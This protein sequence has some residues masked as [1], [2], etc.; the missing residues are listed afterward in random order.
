MRYIGLD[1]HQRLT[2]VVWLD[3]ETGE[4]SEAYEVP[5][6]EL[7]DHLG[8]LAGA[9]KKAVLEAGTQSHFL[10]R[11]LMTLGLEVQV[12]HP[13]RVRRLFEALYGLK[14]T[15]KIDARGLALALAD[16]YLERAGV[17][18]ADPPTHELRALTR[19]R[20]QLVECN[21][22]LRNSIRQLVEQ[23]GEVCPYRDLTGRGATEWL[24]EF[25]EG[26]PEPIRLAL[27]A[28]RATLAVM[29]AQIKELSREI[30]QLVKARAEVELLETIPGIGTET[31]AAIVAEI[32]DISRFETATALRGYS[33]LVP[34]VDQSAGK[35]R[36]GP[37]TKRGNRRLRRI[38]ILA[39]QHF[40]Q[41]KATR[42]LS[43]RKWHARQVFRHGPNPAKV[44]V[45]RR[46][47]N[48]IFALLR[49]QAAFDASRYA[50]PDAA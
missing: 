14:K 2:T 48:I 28:Q 15:D 30:A 21:V 39:A 13:F 43:L 11:R 8:S 1:V 38:M 4:M 46:L 45:A 32:G 41:V 37:L 40:V 44:A 19:T 49:D 26:Q 36:T 16:G 20:L 10:A 24:D 34:K 5:T 42:D 9:R 6:A 47:L 50:L 29:V 33:G 27:E 3:S 22:R 23:E 17:W 18:V 25:A 12:V 31:A 35:L 7:V